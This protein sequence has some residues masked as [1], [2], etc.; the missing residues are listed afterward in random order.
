[1]GWPET[2]VEELNAAAGR[3]A[4]CC[5]R[6]ALAVVLRLAGEVYQARGALTVQAAFGSEAAEAALRAG[7]RWRQGRSPLPPCRPSIVIGQYWN[8]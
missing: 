7:P 6:A 5:R 8:V 1:M 3:A 4:P 2:I